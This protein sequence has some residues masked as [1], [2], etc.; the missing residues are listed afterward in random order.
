MGFQWPPGRGIPG[1]VL[2]SKKTHVTNDAANDPLVSPEM[3]LTLGLRNVLCVPVFDVH[4][5]VIAFFALHD[6]E[7]GDFLPADVEIAEGIAQV[8]SIAI[9]NALAYRRIQ[10]AEEALRRLSTR[11]INTQDEERRRIARELHEATAQDLAAIRMSLG[12]LERSSPRPSIP[13]REALEESLHLCDQAISDI[14]TLSYLLHPP[15]LEEAGLR[16]A[17]KWYALGFSKRSGIGVNLEIPENLGRLPRDHETTLFRILQECLTN[18]HSHS[19]G[20]QAQ[21]RVTR[22]SGYVS[23]EVQDDGKGMAG[24]QNRD[25][26]PDVEMGVGIP[27]MRERVRQFH[28]TFE[29][30]SAPGRGTT[31]RVLLPLA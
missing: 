13:A 3:L 10:Q 11:L 27:G 18:I 14:R 21:I 29:L 26:P 8:A 9:Q 12:R 7:G 2:E 22:E 16:S 20:Q 15:I 4:A 19:G 24:L 23:M 28:G 31:V 30:L 17:V 5:E 1:R 6:K 25:A